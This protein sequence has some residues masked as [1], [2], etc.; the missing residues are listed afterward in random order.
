M[1]GY[2]GKGL[3]L[4]SASVKRP[5]RHQFGPAGAFFTASIDLADF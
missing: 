4:V 3:K 5:D 2:K 1:E